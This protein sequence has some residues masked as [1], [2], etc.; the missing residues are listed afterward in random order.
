VD[1]LVECPAGC[2]V[3]DQQNTLALPLFDEFVQEVGDSFDRLPPALSAG[4]RRIES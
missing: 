2:H 3:T 4:E 1:E